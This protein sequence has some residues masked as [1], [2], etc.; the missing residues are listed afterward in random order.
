ML[1]PTPSRRP[2][3]H[4]WILTLS[5]YTQLRMQN[6]LANLTRFLV[7]THMDDEPDLVDW[8]DMPPVFK[9]MATDFDAEAYP[10][11]P[12]APIVSDQWPASPGG[13]V[14]GP[15]RAC[16]VPTPL[17]KGPRVAPGIYPAHTL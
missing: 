15:L 8:A 10:G 12:N 6:M 3:H 1:L 11:D 17:C 16:H 13:L 14:G 9:R 5:S 2:V 7:S 4:S